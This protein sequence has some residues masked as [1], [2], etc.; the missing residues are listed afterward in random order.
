M[1]IILII[2]LILNVN[3]FASTTKDSATSI[4]KAKETNNKKKNYKS[5]PID[6]S[7]PL[8]SKDLKM[9]TSNP[10]IKSLEDTFDL[11]KQE[12]KKTKEKWQ[13]RSSKFLSEAT[14]KRHLRAQQYLLS[15]NY[16]SAIPVL[17]RV[18]QRQSSTDYEVAKTKV[19][20][21][22][23]YTAKEDYASAELNLKEALVLETLSYME[24]C[25]ALLNLSQVQLSSKNLIE[26]KKNILKYIEI[27]NPS[28]APWVML[29]A[30]EFQNEDYPKAQIA[31]DKAIGM[32]KKPQ[33][34]WLYLAASIHYKNKSYQVAEKYFVDLIALKQTN[35]VYWMSL[36]G[37]LFEQ[38]K[39]SDALTYYEMANKLG[40]VESESDV[41][42]RV[43]LM[44]SDEIP[45]K[46]ASELAEA[47]KLKK[48]EVKKET[49]ESLA[50]YWF[51]AKEFDKA[52]EAYEKAS[53]KAKDG[54]V[55]LMLGQVYL[56]M[57]KWTAAQNAFNK[58]IQKGKLETQA[59]QAYMGMA[60]SSFFNNEKDKAVKYF[61]KAKD[62]KNQK[63]AAE[64]WIGFLN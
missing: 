35:K 10:K 48:I 62:F 28:A 18:I 39:L 38:N 34:P 36:I 7:F 21:S 46:A 63:E 13:I 31:I 42:S 20:L 23:V 50:G 1:K 19:L 30:I 55:D 14:Q 49:Y 43:G 47:I 59:G 24:S 44:F 12:A 33:E 25:E 41:L 40:F 29:A 3:S 9:N 8:K 32:V 17:N 16:D 5:N 11:V 2:L 56:E 26:S 53:E 61:S 45:Y 15:K 22:K 6:P 57:E 58:A 4:E 27:A 52:V 51:S 64:K 60:L 54:K 37:V